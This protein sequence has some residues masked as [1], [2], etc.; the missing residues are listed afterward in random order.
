M[1]LK[2]KH[3]TMNTLSYY[4]VCDYAALYLYKAALPQR[5]DADIIFPAEEAKLDWGLLLYLQG[6]Q[7]GR[8]MELFMF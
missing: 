7:P 2:W 8:T 1:K 3:Y 6:L 5:F 4:L